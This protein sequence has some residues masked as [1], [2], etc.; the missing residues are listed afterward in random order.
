M[1]CNGTGSDQANGFLGK[2]PRA[3][4]IADHNL[5][6]LITWETH[7]ANIARPRANWRPPR[8]QSDGPAQERRSLLQ[9]LPPCGQFRRIMKTAY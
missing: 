9:A 1:L 8:G 6:G 4:L 2:T 7:E 3:V 5:P